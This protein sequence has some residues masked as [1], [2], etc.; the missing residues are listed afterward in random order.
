MRMRNKKNQ[1][2]KLSIFI[3]QACNSGAPEPNIHEWTLR[4]ARLDNWENHLYSV[5]ANAT[6]R[7]TIL[8]SHDTQ[9]KTKMP[10]FRVQANEEY[11]TSPRREKDNLRTQKIKYDIIENW[12]K[13]AKKCPPAQGFLIS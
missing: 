1:I 13:W 12:K 5:W 10:R 6:K 3:L 2:W 8:Y 7:T 4:N 11:N 9:T